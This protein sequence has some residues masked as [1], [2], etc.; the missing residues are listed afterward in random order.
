MHQ[1]CLNVSIIEIVSR[2]SLNPLLSNEMPK[3]Y[4]CLV[5][6]HICYKIRSARF[7]QFKG[8]YCNIAEL[9]G[10]WGEGDLLGVIC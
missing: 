9:K 3:Y 2:A 10:L 4:A 1:D 5:I 6:E 8:L 7:D